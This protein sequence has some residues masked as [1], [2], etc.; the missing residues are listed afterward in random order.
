MATIRDIANKADVS[1][2][3]V[4]R[5]LNNDETLSVQENTRKRIWKVAEELQ[6]ITKQSR[7][8]KGKGLSLGIFLCQSVE[9]ELS[10]PYFLS[11]RQGIENEANKHG[12][13]QTNILR[14]H[15]YSKIPLVEDLDGLIVIGRVN[16]TLVKKMGI[17]PER[18][19]YV[20]YSPDDSLYD[21]V[22][23][24]FKKAT[25]LVIDHL[26]NHGYKNLGFIGG[27]Q[28]EH[29]N[30]VQDC[31]NDDRQITFESRLREKNLFKKSNVYI[32]DYTMTDGY[33]LMKK[34]ISSKKLPEAFVVASD[35]MAVGA[36]RALQESGLKVPEDVALV[37]FDDIEM[38]QFAS[39]SLTT[40]RVHTELM[41]R[42]A[43]KL[44]L[45]R[46]DGRNIPYKVTI[47]TELMVRDSCG[48]LQ[49]KI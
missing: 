45:D 7:K 41:G 48:I 29:S 2:S 49:E 33:Q 4:S 46:M 3:T 34:A 23:V 36:L 17:S 5:V 37:S 11:I 32:G 13:S 25:I 38:A 39:S 6:Y 21:A 8:K 24:D 27:K 44:L 42:T 28:M 14:L 43:V 26:L 16:P 47:P 18:V 15:D 31:L 20:D 10:D 19:V 12:I 9:E 22:V 30:T 40:I 35:P 1:I